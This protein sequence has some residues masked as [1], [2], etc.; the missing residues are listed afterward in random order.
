MM[1]K[2]EK[3]SF[4]VTFQYRV[5]RSDSDNST[6]QF[7]FTVLG[8]MYFICV[9]FWFTNKIFIDCYTTIRKYQK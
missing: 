9:Y 1:H 2:W 7:Y 8:Y 5:C 3:Q 6:S 4:A